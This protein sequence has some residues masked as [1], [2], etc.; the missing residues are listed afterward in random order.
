MSCRRLLARTLRAHLIS[1]PFPQQCCSSSPAHALS[2]NA[3]HLPRG[4]SQHHPQN[5]K[6]ASF[7]SITQPRPHS[8]Q[9]RPPVRT[10]PART[11]FSP[12][13]Q[14][15]LQH[16]A[17]TSLQELLVFANQPDAGSVTPL[18]ASRLSRPFLVVWLKSSM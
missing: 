13:E 18:S 12:I 16:C 1:R 3:G 7:P 11:S 8:L 2:T 6:Q 9:P 4:L 10:T 5:K 14:L 15:L 17:S